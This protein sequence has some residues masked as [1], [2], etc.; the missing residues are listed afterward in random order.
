[1]EDKTMCQKEPTDG[2]KFFIIS[3]IS[4]LLNAPMSSC[5]PEPVIRTINWRVGRAPSGRAECP[6]GDVA[7]HLSR[8]LAGEKPA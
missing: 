2:A 8:L 6:S 1:M 5:G 3:R 4:V 7:S